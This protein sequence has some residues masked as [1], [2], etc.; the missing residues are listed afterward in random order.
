MLSPLLRTTEQKKKQLSKYYCSLQCTW[1]LRTLMDVYTEIKVVFLPANTSILQPW[2]KVKFLLPS[3]IISK[4]YSNH[5]QWF[6]CWFWAKSVENL[7]ASIHH[8]SVFVFPGMHPFH[9]LSNLL[10]IL[11]FTTLS[12]SLLFLQ[13]RGPICLYF[14]NMSFLS[15]FLPCQSS[16]RFVNFVLFKDITF[17]FSLLLFQ[18]LFYFFFPLFFFFFFFHFFLGGAT[19]TPI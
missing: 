11:L 2:I 4:E 9:K 12:S 8:Q 19:F 3:L 7:L 13:N 14:S 10:A 17:S 1:S 5:Q 18:S 16:L 6:L 15:L